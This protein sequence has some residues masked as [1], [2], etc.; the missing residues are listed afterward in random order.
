MA[1]QGHL[2]RADVAVKVFAARALRDFGDGF[3]VLLLPFYLAARGLDAFA[4]GVVATLGLFGSAITTIAI[5]LVSRRFGE[6]GL[7][8]AASLL[9]A[10]TGLAFA[11]SDVT[12]LFF[13]IAFVGTINPSSGSVSIFVPLE[14][15]LLAGAVADR[16]R[17]TTFARYSLIG[18]LAAA[19]GSLAAASPEVLARVGV[20]EIGAFQLMFLA[21]A[22]LGL[23]GGV[24]Y[25][26]LPREGSHTAQVKADPLTRS[27][28]VVFRLATL[29]SVDAFAGGF[30]VP[31]LM[32]LW[33][34]Q[35]F[36]LSLASAGGFFM[37]TGLLGAISQPV[38]GWLGARIGLVNTMVWTHVPASLAL[39]AAA[40][41]PS[42]ELA[43]A[44]LLLR[45]LLSQM[46]VPARTSY[47]M[48][49]VAPEERAAAASITA[50]PRSLA[51]AVSP[52]LAGAL[53]AAGHGAYPL[54]ICGILKIAYDLTLLA[55]F[56]NVRPLEELHA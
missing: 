37:V 56:R 11:I 19:L 36:D 30:V 2:K 42:L 26:R 7:L 33:L 40:F 5:G 16:E 20:S 8:I 46:D 52:A 45:A 53:F 50:V 24:I 10:A 23:A 27:R 35:K 4:I 15:A 22:V 28:V 25:A 38:A 55:L 32:A 18:A 12:A 3:I 41:A 1:S 43:L 44:F 13:M 9:M 54:V 17:T 51:A 29:F 21:Y 6:R 31:A 49:V 47:V 48:A 39:I 14:H 34:L